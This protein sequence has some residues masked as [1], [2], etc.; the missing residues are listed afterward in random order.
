VQRKRGSIV[1]MQP[2]TKNS[3]FLFYASFTLGYREGH[4][5]KY[6]AAFTHLPTGVTAITG[7]YLPFKSG[8][9]VN[10][11][12]PVVLYS[13]FPGATAGSQ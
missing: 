10:A 11:F 1:A 6:R 3:F 9:T 4:N 13:I 12:V 5:F 2:A 7:P 8:R